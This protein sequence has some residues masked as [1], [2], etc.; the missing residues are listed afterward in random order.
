MEGWNVGRIHNMA[1]PPCH[2]TYQWFVTSDGKL[3]ASMQQRSVDALLGLP[4][5]VCNLALVTHLLAHDCG[6]QA[7]EIVWFG[8]DTHIYDNHHEAV[9]I[10]LEREPKPFPTFKILCESKPVYD[11]T[12]DDLIIEGYEHHPAISA[13]VAV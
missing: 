4:F 13:D 11:Y 9:R 8:V 3:N 10:Q 2:K 1:L 5:N 7:G 6:F 12:I